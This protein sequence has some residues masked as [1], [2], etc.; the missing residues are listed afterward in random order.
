MEA[1]KHGGGGSNI[2]VDPNILDLSESGEQISFTCLAELLARRGVFL[3]KNSLYKSVFFHWRA[4][5][6]TMSGLHSLQRKTTIKVYTSGNC[7]Y[8]FNS[9]DSFDNSL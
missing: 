9:P 3:N 8:R 1:G 5:L 6:T 4:S 2:C 7:N